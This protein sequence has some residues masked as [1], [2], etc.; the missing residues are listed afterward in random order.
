M[1][2]VRLKILMDI[3]TVEDIYYELVKRECQGCVYQSSSQRD[4]EFCFLPWNH[5]SKLYLQKLATEIHQRGL[6]IE[7]H[8]DLSQI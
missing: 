6:V 7:E 1:S 8:D 3:Q 4:H 5:A 2:K